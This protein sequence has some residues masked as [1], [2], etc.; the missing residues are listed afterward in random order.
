M[1][2]ALDPENRLSK[3][4]EH[5][6][7]DERALTIPK[8]LGLLLVA[9]L[10]IHIALLSHD[11]SSHFEP[12]LR[13]DRSEVRWIAL[14]QFA[15]SLPVSPLDALTNSP[16]APAEF[17]FQFTAYE[18]GGQTGIIVMQIALFLTSLWALSKTALILLRS[19]AAMLT[20]GAI[21]T[22]LPQNLAFT[23][24]LVTGHR[25]SSRRSFVLF[26]SSLFLSAT[27]QSFNGQ[28]HFTGI[29][30]PCASDNRTGIAA[31]CA[32]A[33]RV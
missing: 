27:V 7:W 25:D 3:S 13:G 26:L 31:I 32:V 4:M 30:Y 20:V 19:R 24:Q 1:P 14:T 22:L 11:L 21:Y 8:E 18:I 33:F 17:L 6:N 9:A 29:G 16:V 23:H 28:R 10:A 12:F 2:A 5:A 15:A